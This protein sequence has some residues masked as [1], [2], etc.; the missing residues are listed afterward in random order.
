M[1]YAPGNK[2]LRDKIRLG[3]NYTAGILLKPHIFYGGGVNLSTADSDHLSA[4]DKIIPGS[5]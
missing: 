3:A 4:N 1:R 5:D 2:L